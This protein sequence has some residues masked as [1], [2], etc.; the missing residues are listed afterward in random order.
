M[1]ILRIMLLP[2]ALAACSGDIYLRDGVTDGDTFYLAQQALAD[3]DPVLQSWVS[4]SLTLSACQLSAGSLNPARASSFD[5]ELL[6]R[7]HLTETWEDLGRG[8]TDPYLD[9]LLRVERAGWLPEY[10]AANHG[11]DHWVFP[12]TLDPP[13]YR[14]FARSELAQHRPVTRLI[15]SWN[16]ASRVQPA[17]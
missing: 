11:R 15:G 13:A 17:P 7:R 16:Y 9:A 14:T 6:A 5:C 4:Y 2:L 1:N 8:T 3:S 10:V 12:D